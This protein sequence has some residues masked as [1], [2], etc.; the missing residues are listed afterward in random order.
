MRVGELKTKTFVIASMLSMMALL[1]APA[2][3]AAEAGKKYQITLDLAVQA[4]CPF[5]ISIQRGAEKAASELGVDLYTT[6]PPTADTASQIQQLSGVIANKPDLLILQPFDAGALMP[7]VGDFKAAGIPTITVDS[8]LADPKARLTLISSD[9]AQGGKSAAEALAK[10]LPKGGKVVFFGYPPGLAGTDARQKG[11]ETEI[12]KNADITY[13]GA[14]YS[15]DDQSKVA[16]QL[17]AILQSDPD[18]KGIFAAAESHAIGVAAAI[19][20][21]NLQGKITV[22]GFD[23]APD[24]VVALKEGTLSLLIVQKAAEMGHR[25]IVDAVAYLKD[26]KVPP[27]EQYTDYVQVTRDNINDP[28]IA[29]YLYPAQ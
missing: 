26:G 15:A 28:D 22:V 8:D 20:E 3:S 27:S 14:Q 10:L 18:V 24:E 19:R 21:A 29:Q 1:N 16:A 13:L 4:G 9:N 12:A 25:A 23:G 5:C 7:V 2:A 17:A 6:S 11:F